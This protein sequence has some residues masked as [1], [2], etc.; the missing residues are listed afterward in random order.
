M[1]TNVYQLLK[2]IKLKTVPD[3]W[4]EAQITISKEEIHLDSILKLKDPPVI[5]G[6]NTLVGHLDNIILGESDTQS[7]QV[8]LVNN[9]AIG[10]STCFDN[11]EARCMSYVKAHSIA[12]GGTGITIQ[13]YKH[14]LSCLTKK[15]FLPE[16]P[17]YSSY[18]CG[19]VIPAAHWAKYVLSYI[20]NNID[21]TY[22]F[23]RK[24]GI[25]FINGSFIHVGLALSNIS[26]LQKVWNSF[27]T[28][29]LLNAI[30][31]KA[32]ISNYTSY[33]STEC[34]D[35][36][37]K[38][39]NWV[40][41]Y[42]DNNQDSYN[43]QDPISVRAFPQNCFALGKCIDIFLESLEI[44]LQRRSDNPLVTID[45]KTP[46]SQA[47]FLSP[48]LT[49]ATGQLIESL[50]LVMWSIERRVHYLL[51]GNVEGIQL[52]G[53]N[54]GLGFIQVPKLL[55][56]ILEESRMIGGRRIFSSGSSTSYGI[57]D[58]WSFGLHTLEILNNIIN[59]LLRMVSIELTVTLLCQSHKLRV[60]ELFKALDQS[61]LKDQPLTELF[62]E[63]ESKIEQ[64]RLP[65]NYE[66]F[67]PYNQ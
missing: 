25:S 31:C 20:N 35:P 51:S 36:I 10:S 14:L 11:Y 43:Q 13:T 47:S 57:E 21:N 62:K 12:N 5:Y 28:S 41:T 17:K 55:T 39:C 38:I 37:I 59:N 27:L 50:L 9:H 22:A 67:Y 15:D 8:N 4:I 65:F 24:E 49:V 42:I 64:D 52:N 56:S 3:E 19:D 44:E 1:H 53:S 46:Y 60:P 2:H 6:V 30:V 40:N 34:R 63:M 54:R 26:R 33:L 16:I 29:S 48:M 7:F 23:K 32:N 66:R 61:I 58:M 45:D 18:S